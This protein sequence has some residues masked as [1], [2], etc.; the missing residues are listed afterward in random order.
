MCI[1]VLATKR[2]LFQKFELHVFPYFNIDV[3]PELVTNNNFT[4]EKGY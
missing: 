2:D 1:E 4:D 3:Q